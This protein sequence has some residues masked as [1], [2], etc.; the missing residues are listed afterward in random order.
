LEAGTARVR[1][2]AGEERRLAP[3]PSPLALLLRRW[4][5]RTA[6]LEWGEHDAS[7]P[8]NSPLLPLSVS[9]RLLNSLRERDCESSQPIGSTTWRSLPGGSRALPG[10]EFRT[11]RRR[12]LHHSPRPLRAAPGSAWAWGP[13]AQPAH[14]SAA[15]GRHAGRCSARSEPDGGCDLRICDDEVGLVGKNCSHRKLQVLSPMERA[16]G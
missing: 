16:G 15:A 8:S 13:A 4:I 2:R 9:P 14:V 7:W 12:H 6:W 1:G 5:G 10:P 3:S 11:R